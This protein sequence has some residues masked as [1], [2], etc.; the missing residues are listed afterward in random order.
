MHQVEFPKP[1]TLDPQPSTHNNQPS[2]QTLNPG[3]PTPLHF[4]PPYGGLRPFHQT[5]TCITQV[6]SGPYLVQIWSRTTS[7]F[8]LNETLVV[9]RVV[10]CSIGLY[11]FSKLTFRTTQGPISGKMMCSNAVADHRDFPHG[12]FTAH[13]VRSRAHMRSATLSE[14]QIGTNGENDCWCITCSFGTYKTVKT[15]CWHI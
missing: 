7:E 14:V 8:G 9:N 6:T 11:R 13:R 1:S 5:S 2:A 15:G 4:E 3:N 12:L 10:R